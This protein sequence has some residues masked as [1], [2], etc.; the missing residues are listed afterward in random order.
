MNKMKTFGRMRAAA[1]AA[2][3]I[4]AIALA[5][6]TVLVAARPDARTGPNFPSTQLVD[7]P[8][9]LFESHGDIGPVE[10]PGR[11]VYDPQKQEYLVEGAGVNMWFGTDEFHFV[12]KR[13]KGDFILSA[14]VEFI[15]K[16]V[17]AHRK[18]GWMARSALDTGS[19]HAG[20][21]IHGDGLTS[22]QFRRAPGKDTEEVRMAVQ[23][24]DTIQLERRGD[25]YIMSAAR[26][27]ETFA[28]E[29]IPDIGLGDEVSIGLFVCS[30]D[31]RV[32]EKARFSNVRVVIPAKDGF[33]PYQDYI[34]SHLE[35]MDVEN[36]ERTVVFQSPRSLQ[37]P[38][39]TPAGKALIYNSEGL[40]YRFDLAA[41]APSV[42]ETGPA[43]DNNNDHVLSFD[44]KWIGISRHSPDDAG[45]SIIYV[46]PAGGGEPRVIAYVYGGQG[47]INVPS[48]SPDGRR[49]AFVSNTGI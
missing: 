5:A 20:A 23:A 1:A 40:L 18:A 39:W 35:V 11:T 3:I 46:L 29:R 48:W 25:V 19:A 16:G 38:N 2:M 8:L 26:F 21:V 30:H 45:E 6:G 22:L 14:R 33:V 12:W 15:G 7:Q 37:A 13:L 27:G 44:G 43:K 17:M 47:T 9:G 4:C 24:P 42:L 41:G 36:G 49:I 28:S 31:A 10:L 32:S 34:G